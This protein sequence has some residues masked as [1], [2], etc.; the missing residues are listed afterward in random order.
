LGKNPKALARLSKKYHWV[1]RAAAY[2]AFVG[3]QVGEA[4]AQGQ[5]KQARLYQKLAVKFVEELL[6][7]MEEGTISFGTQALIENALQFFPVFK[8]VTNMLSIAE[9]VCDKRQGPTLNAK[10]T[11]SPLNNSEILKEIRETNHGDEQGSQS[12][13]SEEEKDWERKRLAR[14]TEETRTESEHNTEDAHPQVSSPE[15]PTGD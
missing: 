12:V 2:D 10:E 6:T 5:V 1:K 7:G 9:N 8:D 11:H 3:Q 14:S 13:H 15:I 4:V